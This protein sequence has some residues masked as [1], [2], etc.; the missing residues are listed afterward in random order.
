[1]KNLPPIVGVS[2]WSFHR[3]LGEPEFYGVLEGEAIPVASHNNG[4][5][6]LLELPQ[7][8]AARGFQILEIC[9]FHLPSRDA[10]YLREF[11]SAMQDSNIQLLS[12]LVDEGDITHPQNGA[13]DA[14]WIESWMPVAQELG[15]QKVR[16]IAGQSTPAG[17]LQQSARTLKQLAAR[18]GENGL[19]LTTENWFDV[20]VS[21]QNV[22]QLLDACE[23]QVGFNLDFGNWSGADKY[24]DLAAIA[25]RAESCHAKAE[26]SAAN[27]IEAEDY[28]RC[29]QLM[30]AVNFNGPFTLVSGG[31][32]ENDWQ[33]VERARDF[34]TDFF[35]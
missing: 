18:A 1:M 12:L 29:L 15:A 13:R 35:S 24:E 19:R 7:Q 3:N 10:G 9:H 21:P 2:S 31:V 11:K 4:A 28:A 6:T 14:A 20:L 25:P 27:E 16:V 5:T 22:L 34:I 26:Y 30:G 17:A 8:M 23:G 33:G 32:G